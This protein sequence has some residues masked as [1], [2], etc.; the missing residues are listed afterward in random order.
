MSHRAAQKLSS[1]DHGPTSRATKASCVLRDARQVSIHWR[2]GPL[3]AHRVIDRLGL[4]PHPGR[5]PVRRDLSLSRA[6]DARGYSTAIYYLLK[7]GELS[8]WHRVDAAELWHFYAGAPLELGLS[9]TASRAEARLL[10]IDLDAGER[11]QIVVPAGLVA[12]GAQPRR[13]DAGRL[14]RRARPSA[15]RASRWRHPA[16]RR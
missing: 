8:H 1:I 5:R 12:D 4:R 15:T 11:P 2:D 14:H 10:G 7:P 6:P 3:D 13:L 9:P 16:G